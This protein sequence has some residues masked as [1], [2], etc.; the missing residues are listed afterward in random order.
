MMK[1]AILGALLGTPGYRR[2]GDGA[3]RAVQ[4]SLTGGKG[5]MC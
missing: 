4:K 3:A 1:G 2:V 5:A